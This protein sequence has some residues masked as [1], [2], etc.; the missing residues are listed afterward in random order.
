MM[1]DDELRRSRLAPLLLRLYRAAP[2]RKR[3]LALAG[4]LEG[5]QFYSATM[6]QLLSE[7]HG[8]EIGTYS[9]GSCFEPGA[10]PAGARIGRYVSMAAGVRRRL[11]HPLDRLILHPFFYNERLGFV[12][13]RTVAHAPIEIGHDAWIGESVIFTE[14]CRRV[15]I[16]AAIGAGAVVT[17]DVGDFE[18]MAGVPARKLRQRFD[19]AVCARILDS[20]WWE[21]PVRDLAAYVRDLGGAVAELP[22]GH[23]LLRP[24]CDNVT[25]QSGF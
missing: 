6:R 10:F 25:I 16:G 11:N 24:S 21:R 23:P 5:G 14:G 3:A 1:S 7:H 15:G 13:V 4:R 8:V 9:Y 12:P 19:D 20:R 18:V 17:R 2:F 22:D